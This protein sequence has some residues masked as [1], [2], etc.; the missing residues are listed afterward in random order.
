MKNII[1]LALILTIVSFSSCSKKKNVAPATTTGSTS[2][3]ADNEKINVQYRVTS[4]SGQINVEY[5]TVEDGVAKTNTTKVNRYTF[6]Y[7]F[8]WTKHKKLYVSAS[9]TTPSSK[10]VVVEIYVNGEL[11]RSGKANAAGAVASAEGTVN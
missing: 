10:E 7:S 5:I 1:S 2:T 9:N 11:F 8:D 3:I 4:S 6:S